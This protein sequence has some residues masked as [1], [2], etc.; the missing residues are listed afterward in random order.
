MIPRTRTYALI[1]SLDYAVRGGRVKPAV[2]VAREF[3]APVA[4]S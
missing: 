2:Q 4:R 3:P 1:G